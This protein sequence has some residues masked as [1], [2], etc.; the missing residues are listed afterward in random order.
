MLAAIRRV[1]SFDRGLMMHALGNFLL[2]ASVLIAGGWILLNYS[3]RWT[4]NSVGHVSAQACII[5]L[6]GLALRLLVA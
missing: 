6:I 5:V 3:T 1:S 2:R 4:F